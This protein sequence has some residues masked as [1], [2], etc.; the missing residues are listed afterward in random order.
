LLLDYENND[1]TCYQCNNKIDYQYDKSQNILTISS[2]KDIFKQQILC[3]FGYNIHNYRNIIKNYENIFEDYLQIIQKEYEGDIEKQVKEIDNTLNEFNV[4]Y[5][6]KLTYSD[7]VRH[8]G[9]LHNNVVIHHHPFSG[10][11]L[12]P[13]HRICNLSQV[14][15]L[16][17]NKTNIYFRSIGFDSIFFLNQ[18]I[19]EVLEFF[20]ENEISMIFNGCRLKYMFSDN[21]NMKDSCSQHLYLKLLIK[22]VKKRLLNNVS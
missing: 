10:K 6:L 17:N 9:Y 11:I 13:S 2:F 1:T 15:T 20:G 8:R 3:N 22:I 16:E 18:V 4:L 7:V 5:H 12:G 14:I 19:P 21:F